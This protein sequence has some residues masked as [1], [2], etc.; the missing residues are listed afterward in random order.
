MAYAIDPNQ[1]QQQQGQGVPGQ[2]ATQSSAPVPTAG[3]P[4]AGP[5][6]AKT[7]TGAASPTSA[8]Q[9]FTNLQAYLTANAPQI[10]SQ[11]NTISGNLT[12]Q[13]GQVMNDIGAG[14]Q[15]FN[16]QVSQGYTPENTQMVQQATTAPSTFVQD[17]NNVTAFQSQ[18]NDQYVGP[19]NFEGTTGYSGLNSEV[20]DA[21]A[22]ADLFNTPSGLQTYLQG[23]EKNPTPGI[24][25]LDSVLLQQSPEAIQQVQKAASPFSQLPQYLSDQVTTADQ[26]VGTAT[27]NANKAAQDSQTALLNAITGINQTVGGEQTNAQN[28]VNSYNNLVN[29]YNG[30]LTSDLTTINNAPANF[31]WK[32]LTPDQAWFN[33]S[34]PGAQPV[35]AANPA[36]VASSQDYATEAALS[37]LAG[38]YAGSF[39]AMTLNPSQASLAG[40][41][42][43]PP[44]AIDD[45]ALLQSL[46]DAQNWVNTT[47]F[48]VPGNGNVGPGVYSLSGQNPSDPRYAAIYGDLENYLNSINSE[49]SALKG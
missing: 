45:A 28:S 1:Q 27:A 41:F 32:P 10:Q 44:T 18:L 2:S 9:P 8:A 3:A 39:P 14:T 34:V 7:P 38:Q 37:Q 23:T 35:S 11:A 4:G 31:G 40:T 36:A 12:N 43:A 49:I 25:M 22:N 13:Y 48:Q 5:T 17:P 29:P 19:T 30:Q 26:G 16:Q 46:Q 15:A 6:G 20:T 42:T 47:Q 21:A 33:A 24:S